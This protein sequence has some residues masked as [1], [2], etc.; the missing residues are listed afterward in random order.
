MGKP[1]CQA[2]SGDKKK[3]AIVVLDTRLL[4]EIGGCWFCLVEAKLATFPD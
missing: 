1:S 4:L 2:T 3:K